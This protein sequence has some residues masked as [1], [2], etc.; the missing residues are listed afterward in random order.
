M[1]TCPNLCELYGA[2]FR[3]GHD[4]A[5]ITP[6]E[7]KDPWMMTI[8]CRGGPVIYPHGRD[9]LALEMDYRPQLGKRLLAIP[10]VRLHQSGDRERTFVFS[11]DLFDHVAGVVK[12][13]RKRRLTPKQRAESARRLAPW[14]KKSA[15]QSGISTLEPQMS[16]QDGP[17]PTPE[18]L[19]S[20]N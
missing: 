1:T 2:C 15:A 7:R 5:A 9:V 17:K 4:A 19:C 8:P 16:A 10:G 3:I 11:V 20:G 12:P 6:T 13:S 18:P 14:R